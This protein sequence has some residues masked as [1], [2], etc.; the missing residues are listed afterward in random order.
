MAIVVGI[1]F[2]ALGLAGF[3]KWFQE[4]IYVAK[5]L[6]PIVL[7]TSG[8]LAVIVGIASLGSRR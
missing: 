7:L 2:I 5:G 1:V 4:F 8:V 6:G 3:L